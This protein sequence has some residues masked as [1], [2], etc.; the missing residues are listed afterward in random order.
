MGRASGA[1]VILAQTLINPF[2]STGRINMRDIKMGPLTDKGN[3][4]PVVS[5]KRYGEEGSATSLEISTR[6][7]GRSV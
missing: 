1:L 4:G 7:T 2:P 6:N 3:N 5:F